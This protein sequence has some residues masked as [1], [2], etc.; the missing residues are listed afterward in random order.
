MLPTMADYDLDFK[1]FSLPA[2]QMKPKRFKIDDDMFTAP[3]II[4]PATFA[5]LT[6]MAGRLAELNLGD[7]DTPLSEELI[8]QLI[9][10][11]GDL[12]VEL[13]DEA[14]GPRFKTRLESKTEP[15][16]LMRQAVPALYWL[17]EAYGLRPTEPPSSSSNG[18]DG[19]GL[20][21]TDGALSDVSSL[22]G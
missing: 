11:F 1:D 9:G 13:L 5:A 6:G 3:P 2:E 19:G 8:N 21:S 15:I 4:A 22:S 18:L 7:G 12:F 14:T 20:G 17:I 10:A 16:D